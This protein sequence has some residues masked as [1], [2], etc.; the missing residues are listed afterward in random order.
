MENRKFRIGIVGCGGMG[1][2]HAIAIQ[3]GTGNA[4]WNGNNLDVPGFDSPHTTDI[5]KLMELAGIVD[6]KP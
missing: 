6:I 5:S 4:I 1:G 3:S 2:G